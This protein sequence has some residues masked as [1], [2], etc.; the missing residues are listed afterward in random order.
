MLPAVVVGAAILQVAV[1]RL[2][3]VGGVIQRV[4]H[5]QRR[6]QVFVLPVRHKVCQLD[7]TTGGHGGGNVIIIFRFGG[8]AEVHRDAPVCGDMRN[9]ILRH[10]LRHGEIPH[11]T[12]VFVAHHKAVERPGLPARPAGALCIALPAVIADKRAGFGVKLHDMA[13]T[14][15]CAD[16]VCR[17]GVGVGHGNFFKARVLG[18]LARP[19]QKRNVEQAVDDRPAAGVRVGA[20]DVVPRADVPRWVEPPCQQLGGV[21]PAAAGIGI[22][23]QAVV[24][25]GAGQPHKANI[26]VQ[27]VVARK[28]LVER[29]LG[30]AGNLGIAV[31]MGRV[32]G[33]PQ[34]SRPKAVC[35]PAEAVIGGVAAAIGFVVV[36]TVHGTVGDFLGAALAHGAQ[37]VF[38]AVS[39]GFSPIPFVVNQVQHGR[40]SFFKN[41]SQGGGH[42]AGCRDRPLFVSG[43][44]RIRPPRPDLLDRK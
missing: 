23:G 17:H 13:H 37:L 39:S 14:A 30:K 41:T 3:P 38:K 29:A 35:P 19:I 11:R 34:H 20:G 10:L 1:T 12:R 32:V 27:A 44:F 40:F 7:Q 2:V 8:L 16:K 33:L 22:A 25:H 28:A 18:F 36:Y 6:G 9:K 24:R 31:I 4:Q 42:S 43:Q 26:M 15:V 5:F 21:Q